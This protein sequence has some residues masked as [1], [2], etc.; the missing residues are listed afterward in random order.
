M[1]RRSFWLGALV[2]LTRI[3]CTQARARAAASTT[4]TATGASKAIRS[5]VNAALRAIVSSPTTLYGLILALRP[6]PIPC[7]YNSLT[8]THAIL[9]SSRNCANWQ[10]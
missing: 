8:P 10:D 1:W 7:T 5:M 6:C 2:R 3:S 4:L 9:P